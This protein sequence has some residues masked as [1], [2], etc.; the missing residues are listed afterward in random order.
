MFADIRQS[1]AVRSKNISS[2]LGERLMRVPAARHHVGQ[3]RPAHEGSVIAVAARDLLYRAAEEQHRIRRGDSWHRGERELEL[4]RAELDLEGAQ[5]Q[6]Q[7]FKVFSQ[8]LNNGIY[9]VV[10]L[11][12]QVFVALLA[13]CLQGTTADLPRA[14]GYRPAILELELA[15]HPAGVRRPGQ[16]PEGRRVGAHQDV[17]GALHLG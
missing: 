6:P 2:I 11:L 10:A 8:Y 3:L 13:Q 5:W 9:Q 7:L 15:Q 16:H 14:K 12:G 1:F 4:A 17:R